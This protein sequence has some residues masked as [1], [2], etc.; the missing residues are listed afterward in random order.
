MLK[1]LS[2][3]DFVENIDYQRPQLGALVNR[4]QGGGIPPIIYYFHPRAFK[5]MLMRNRNTAEYAKYY[6]ISRRMHL[7]LQ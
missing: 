3:N 7:L 5:L 4:A 1:T 2:F 6:Y